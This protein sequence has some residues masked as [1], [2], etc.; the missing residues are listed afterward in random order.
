MGR[1]FAAMSMFPNSGEMVAGMATIRIPLYRSRYSAH[2]RQAV[3][4]LQSVDYHRTETDNR[5][6]TELEQ[7]LEQ[8]RESVRST[9]L[10]DQELIPRAEQALGILSEEY[11]SGNVS[12]DEV[13]RLQEQLLELELEQIEV[14]VKQHKAIIR[15]ETLV[16]DVVPYQHS[17][18]INK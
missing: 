1:D 7:A 13:L 11:S 9:T 14:L 18:E 17:T 4:Q 12:F 2:Y 15:I 5:L 3:E 10:L 6:S 8:Y 16:G